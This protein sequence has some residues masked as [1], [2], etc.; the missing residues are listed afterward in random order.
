MKTKNL[1]YIIL[2][3]LTL[4]DQ[5][6]A[7][8]RPLN[9]FFRTGI[10][11]R[12]HLYDFVLD[13]NQIFYKKLKGTEWLPLNLPLEI[14]KDKKIVDFKVDNRYL[15]LRDSL[16][17]VYK[18]KQA[19]IE[20]LNKMEWTKN[21]GHPVGKGPGITIP[22][23][24]TLWEVQDW[25]WVEDKY[26]KDEPS[27]QRYRSLS[28]AHLYM[29]HPKTN[30]ISVHDP[31]LPTNDFSYELCLP[32]KGEFIPH[33]FTA[34]GEYVAVMNSYGD[35]F[36]RP[37]NLDL[38]GYNQVYAKYYY[39]DPKPKE[40][41]INPL[42]E[43][44]RPIRLP[45]LDW[46]QRKKIKGEITD[47]ISLIKTDNKNRVFELRVE[48]IQNKKTGYYYQLTDQKEWKFV[49]TNLPL[50]GRLLDNKSFDSSKLLVNK[51]RKSYSYSLDKKDFKII[52]H[53]FLPHCSPTSVSII[54]PDNT[55]LNANLHL[56]GTYRFKPRAMGLDAE[57]LKLRGALE[58]SSKDLKE[59][60]GLSKKFLKEH[61]KKGKRFLPLKAEATNEGLTLELS[62]LKKWEFKI[63]P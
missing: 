15:L 25:D 28:I 3:T 57:S 5:P 48:G 18:S 2:F 47:L 53:S 63:L 56:R 1:I 35:I 43:F 41:N 61:F 39:D 10:E 36:T 33:S 59:S 13:H 17:Q 27:K 34:S 62:L 30:S 50:K 16:G 52:I 58:I 12:N 31:F 6:K 46:E 24:V 38:V 42:Y 55:L 23:D 21:W 19:L 11:G 49:E 37:W 8:E 45:S 51:S 32:Y 9:I 44:F 54:F 20:D 29:Y 60:K 14:F 22:P 26:W 40:R 7:Q 4:F